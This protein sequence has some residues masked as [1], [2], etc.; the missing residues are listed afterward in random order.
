MTARTAAR[1]SARGGLILAATGRFDVGDIAM[2]PDGELVAFEMNETGNNAD[3]N[4]D[5]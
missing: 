1:R 2:R 4:H 5:D 3:N